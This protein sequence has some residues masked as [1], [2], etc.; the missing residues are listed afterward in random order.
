MKTL[1]NILCLTLLLLASCQPNSSQNNASLKEETGT[2]HPSKE[3]RQADVLAKDTLNA[4]QDEVVRKPT[5]GTT[6]DFEV[7][8]EK[9][10]RTAE[11]QDTK[12]FNSCIDPKT[13]LYIIDAPGAVPR[14]TYLKDISRYE[15]PH[16]QERAFSITKGI[17]RNC[18]LE[19]VQ[20]L[21]TLTCQGDD[22]NFARRGCFVADAVA[23]R[24]SEAPKF[25]GLSTQEENNAA[26]TQ[27]LVNKTVLHT[28]SG[29]KFHFGRIKGNWRVLFIDLTVPCSA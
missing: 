12:E 8:F 14:F 1:K 21:P 23:F 29:F 16:T 11:Q 20:T 3:H 2:V 15:H 9:F 25:A 10:K 5:V 19:A 28:K 13:G 7:F 4:V 24:E 22:D 27:L 26:Q 18:D 6:P 17:F